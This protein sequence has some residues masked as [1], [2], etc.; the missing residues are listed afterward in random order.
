[1]RFT[2]ISGLGNYLQQ[3]KP[4]LKSKHRPVPARRGGGETS[5]GPRHLRWRGVGAPEGDEGTPASPAAQGSGGG[6]AEPRR[7]LLPPQLCCHTSC[8]LQAH[9]RRLWPGGDTQAMAARAPAVTL[10]HPGAAPAAAC[11]GAGPGGASQVWV[12]C[13]QKVGLVG[14]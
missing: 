4:P 1:M 8:Q 5:P 14:F 7:A 10:C 12:Q 2:V 13:G 11:G 6:A 9:G 3:T